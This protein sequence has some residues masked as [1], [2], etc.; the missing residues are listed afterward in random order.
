MWRF[1]RGVVPLP[2]RRWTV[3]RYEI[4]LSQRVLTAG[5]TARALFPYRKPGNPTLNDWRALLDSGFPFVKRELLRDNPTEETDLGT[6]QSAVPAA[7]AA[8]IEEDLRRY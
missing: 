1:W 3:G 7:Y 4:G 6:W 8:E 5:L 2:F